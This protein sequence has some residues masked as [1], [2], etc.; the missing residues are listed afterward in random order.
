M[1]KRFGFV[2]EGRRPKEIKLTPGKHVDDILIFK[3]IKGDLDNEHQ[4]L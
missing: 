1:Y 3:F 4:S 2:E